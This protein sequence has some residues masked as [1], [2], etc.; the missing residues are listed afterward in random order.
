MVTCVPDL[1]F[2]NFT[3]E[4]HISRDEINPHGRLYVILRLSGCRIQ[5]RGFSNRDITHQYNYRIT[6]MVTFILGLVHVLLF[7]SF[8]SLCV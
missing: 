2:D 1:Y 6:V 7:L 5:E 3:L 8:L 4:H